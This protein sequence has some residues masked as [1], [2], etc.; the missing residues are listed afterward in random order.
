MF[1]EKT[2]KESDINNKVKVN[3]VFI[4]FCFYVYNYLNSIKLKWRKLPSNSN[5]TF[6]FGNKLPA[7]Q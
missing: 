2:V 4:M 3:L 7:F 5:K 6:F 1:C